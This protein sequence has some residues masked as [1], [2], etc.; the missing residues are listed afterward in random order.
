M[1]TQRGVTEHLKTWMDADSIQAAAKAAADCAAEFDG[2]YT[3][4]AKNLLARTPDL[5]L[6]LSAFAAG[7][8]AGI[9][10]EAARH[11]PE[12]QTIQI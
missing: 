5:M 8:Q 3:E 12:Q 10:A 9:A 11:Q 7:K 2:L 6:L 1:A 4:S